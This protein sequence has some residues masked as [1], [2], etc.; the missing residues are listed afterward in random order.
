MGRFPIVTQRMKRSRDRWA[1]KNLL[2]GI[3]NYRGI[4]D[5]NVANKSMAYKNKPSTIILETITH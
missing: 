1:K 2:T 5:S 3:Y 4:M